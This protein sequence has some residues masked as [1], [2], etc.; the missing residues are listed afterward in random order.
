MKKFKNIF[1]GLSLVLAG[2]LFMAFALPQD[3]K[4][5]G[6]WEIPAKYKTM[7]N[8]IKDD[9]SSLKIG[10]MLYTKHCKSCHGSN[11]LGDGP[12]ARSMKTA[13]PPFNCEKFQAQ[14]DGVLYYQSIIGRDEMPNYEKKI[15]DEE[16][17]WALINYLRTLK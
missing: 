9:A 1:L 15:L 11:G 17:R 4:M 5:G 8:T 13:I 6:P 10:K 12:K 2:A 7:K 3:K 16:D 14:T